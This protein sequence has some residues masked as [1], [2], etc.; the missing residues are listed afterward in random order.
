MLI[1]YDS[2]LTID[3]ITLV[4]ELVEMIQNVL[5]QQAA[6]ITILINMGNKF[7]NFYLK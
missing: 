1:K 2:T 6:F 3:T 7:N 4:H 5:L